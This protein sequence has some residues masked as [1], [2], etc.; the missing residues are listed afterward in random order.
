MQTLPSGILFL[1][2]PPKPPTPTQLPPAWS[3]CVSRT[4]SHIFH[5]VK[6]EACLLL[7]EHQSHKQVEDRIE[8]LCVPAPFF[9]DGGE[10]QGDIGFSSLW[11]RLILKLDLKFNYFTH[12]RGLRWRVGWGRTTSLFPTPHT[13]PISIS[14]SCSFCGNKPWCHP[15]PPWRPPPHR[16]LTQ[17]RPRAPSPQAQVTLICCGG[18]RGWEV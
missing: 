18:Q 12:V 17:S 5:S 1:L 7:K 3:F 11:N 6:P 10:G 2:Q 16:I 15:H 14:S 8:C 9:C 13:S 4:L